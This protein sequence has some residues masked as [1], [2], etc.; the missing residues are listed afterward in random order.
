LLNDENRAYAAPA[1]K[2][3]EW[4]CFGQMEIIKVKA[5]VSF[6]GL[7]GEALFQAVGNDAADMFSKAA[8]KIHPHPSKELADSIRDLKACA[9]T[10]LEIMAAVLPLWTFGGAAHKRV[11]VEKTG[12]EVGAPLKLKAQDL[13]SWEN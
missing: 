12:V 11:A 1:L 13:H 9:T 6:E 3:V 8:S 2:V 7:E 5:H 4:E 10:V